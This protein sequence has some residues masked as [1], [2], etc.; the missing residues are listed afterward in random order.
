MNTRKASATSLPLLAAA[1]LGLASPARAVEGGAPIT[2]FGVS[3]FGA[4]IMPPPSDVAT[5]MVRTTFYHAGQLRDDAG[6][7]SPVGADIT[8]NSLGAAVIK[9][10]GTSILGARYGYAAVFSLLDMKVDLAIPTPAGPLSMA[11]RKTAMGDISVVPVILQWTSPGW[12]QF[13]ALQVQPPTGSYDKNSL[14]NPGTGHWTWSPTYAFTHIGATGFEVSSAIQVN[15]SARNRHTGYRSGA[16]W[17]Q[18][19]ALGQHAGPYT[20]GLGGY[21]YRQFTDDR[22]AGLANGNRARVLALGPAINFFSPGSKLP[23]VWLH[24]FKEFGARNRSQ[25]TQ[26]ALRAAMAF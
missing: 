19:F 3:G 11:G 1:L 14:I 5:V 24:A 7:R 4:G 23:I 17:Q 9:M 12:F 21:F 15:L 16:E 20:V 8:V 13:A 26:V 25:G 18:E 22:A 10:T 6:D 2:P